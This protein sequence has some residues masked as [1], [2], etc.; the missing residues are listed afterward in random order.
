MLKVVFSGVF[1]FITLPLWTN[2]DLHVDDRNLL[3]PRFLVIRRWG[4]KYCSFLPILTCFQSIILS[5]QW[6]WIFKSPSA[7]IDQAT[8]FVFEHVMILL[9]LTDDAKHREAAWLTFTTLLNGGLAKLIIH[10]ALE[11]WCSRFCKTVNPIFLCLIV[12][13]I[14]E[15]QAWF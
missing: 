5:I 3:R 8:S 14:F 9:L 10:R 6:A 1:V 15:E 13:A 4:R 12:L 7:P 11:L 2:I